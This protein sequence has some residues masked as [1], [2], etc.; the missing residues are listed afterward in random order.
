[1]ESENLRGR[2]LIGGPALFD[3]NFRRAVVL[4]GEHS[5]EGALGVILNRPSETPVRQ[6]VPPLGSLVGPD[7]P[8]F[9]GGPVQGDSAVV[10]AEFEN[11]SVAGLVAFGS[12]GFLVGDIEPTHVEGIR[13]A[14]VFAGYAGWGAGQLEAELQEDGGWLIEEARPE[15]VFTTEPDRLWERVV[16]RRPRPYAFLGTMPFDPSSN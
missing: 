9:V 6:A 5:D 7:E 12:I 16:G 10:I 8:V 11:P 15:D 13:R 14:R 4:V 1:M 3:P 2:L